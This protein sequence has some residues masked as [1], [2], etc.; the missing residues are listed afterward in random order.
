[1]E[2]KGTIIFRKNWD[3]IKGDRRFG[4]NQGGS[5]SS[6]TYSLCQVVIVYCLTNP[7]KLVSVIRKSFPSLRATVMRDFFEVMN[8]VGIYDRKCHNKTD[9][10]YTFPNGAAVE[11]FSADDEQKLRGRKRDIAWCN[12]A[13]E[14]LYDDF[15]QLNLRTTDK[16][17]V[18]YNPSDA[19]SWIYEL[20]DQESVTI[21]STYRDN[22][23]LDKSIIKQIEDLKFKD[24]ALYQIYALGERAASRKNIYSNW[25]FISSRPEKF[26]EFVYGLDFGFNHPSSLVKVYYYEDQIFIETLIY[27][28]YLTTS[29]LINRMHE[30][31]VDQNTE[32][33]C[34]W[35]R[36][37]I[38][39]ELKEAGFYAMNAKK[40]VKEGIDTVKTFHVYLSEE[41]VNLRKEY[42]NYMW[43]KVGDRILDEPVKQWDDAMDA[44]R[45]A[46]MQIKKDTAG[47]GVLISF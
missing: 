20:E 47:N 44:I 37:E 7:G 29:D 24:D 22:P 14:L 11:F 23:F 17:I 4:I 30:L 18:D 34:D 5:R 36:P 21:K 1:M 27:E 46:V 16:L 32:I 42:D 38:I 26:Q 13:N 39:Q 31:D 2:I 3:F 12:E 9:N 41:D 10:M 6:K 45:Y 40:S 25:N 43:R 15:L 8:E 19:S 35:A 28:S 33:M